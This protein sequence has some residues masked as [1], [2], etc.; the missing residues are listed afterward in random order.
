MTKL[1]SVSFGQ[2]QIAK[3][4]FPSQSVRLS[5]AKRFAWVLA[6]VLLLGHSAHAASETWTGASGGDWS[7]VGNWSPTKPGSADTAVFNTNISSVTNSSGTNQS[8]TSISF[9]TAAGSITIGSTGGNSLLLTTAGTIQILSTLAGT[10]HTET[11]NAPLGI[12]AGTTAATY[13]FGNNSA[14]NTSTLNFGGT[15]SG[16][17]TSTV[18]LTLNGANTGANTIN[19]N[20]SNGTSSAL[21]VTKSGAGTWVLSG[22]NTYTGA[23]TVSAGTLSLTGTLTGSG[24]TTSA[25]GTGIFSESSTGVIS[26]ATGSFTQSSNG[27]SV[28]AGN[29][30]YGGA[31]TVN[32]GTLDIGGSSS[33]GSVTGSALVLGGG[34]L[35]YT[36]TGSG[37]QTF[38]G[39]TFTSGQSTINVVSGDT[40][41]LKAINRGIGSTIDFGNSA[42]SVSTTSTGTNGILGGY[43]TFQGNTWAV[44]GGV[45]T[46]LASGSY[47]AA[48]AGTTAVSSTNNI[49]F[50]ASNTTA[51]AGTQ[52]LNS[53]RFNTSTAGTL[54]LSGTLIDGTGGILV[55]S[56]VGSNL[57]TITGG[58]LEGANGQD[59]VAIV[60]DA[61]GLTI[62]SIIANN[63]ASTG[64]TKS[65]TG[66][67]TLTAANTYT[68]ATTIDAGTLI[69]TGTITSSSS[70]VTTVANGSGIILETNTGVISGASTTFTQSS[71]GTSVL[72]GNNTYGG[73]T[74]VNSGTLT[75]SGSNSTSSVTVGGL[76]AATVATLNINN[77]GAI[78]TGALTI[79]AGSTID[80]TSATP[81]T[82]GTNSVA[83]SAFTFGG[84]KDL[85]LGTGAVTDSSNTGAITLNG[86]NSHLTMGTVTDTQSGTNIGL[87]VNGVGNTLT[88]GGY[89][90]SGGSAK[91]NLTVNGTANVAITGVVADSSGSGT[92]STLTYSGTGTLALSG[93]NTYTGGTTINS[94]G[95]MVNNTLG[96]GTGTGAVVVSSGA[97]LGGTGT[98]NTSGVAS[99]KAVDIASNAIL[100]PS[101]GVTTGFSHLHLT[102]QSGSSATLEAGSKLAFNLGSATATSDEV[103]VT[104]GT[105][106]LN[107]QNFSNFTFNAQSGT[108]SGTYTLIDSTGGITG[109]LGTSLTGTFDGG[110]YTG[111]LFLSGNDLDL[112]VVASVPEPST[113][114]MMLGGL[115]LLLIIQRRRNRLNSLNRTIG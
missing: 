52:T 12:G 99:G 32:A 20:I 85:N 14:D 73:A 95:L 45:I 53:L 71:N 63:T 78:G 11:I 82:L 98:I 28:L 51:W 108:T 93:A 68:G 103:L 13:T 1:I 111:T 18:A 100:S 8:I 3:L 7:A 77:A 49:D 6:T 21:S 39:T 69:L 66:T 110:L 15:I 27:T 37:T 79:N 80:N 58:T 59:L 102:L 33:T 96:S 75:L 62:G 43:A 88:L 9:D 40:V 30:T 5:H 54:T 16:S 48:T 109:L 38:T 84:T 4:S 72:A 25:N 114:A 23:T 29:N 57:S 60:N 70:S 113:W 115:G 74:A 2:R 19:G 97:T 101:G 92:L 89:N 31:T 83:F 76:N 112:T 87:T 104:G 94:G 22:T 36:T 35:S 44:G 17:T 105:L 65:G 46:G 106:A 61:G 56:A 91:K 64:L 34:T 24:V 47:T 67:L 90:I 50:Q 107:G 86:I 10:G 41:A 55:T 81:V 26:G 42:G